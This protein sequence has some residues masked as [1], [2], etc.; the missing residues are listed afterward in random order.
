MRQEHRRIGSPVAVV[1]AV[2]R[3][4]GP[5]DGDVGA[6]DAPYPEDDLRS[7]RLMDRT[8]AKDP[9]VGGQERRVS[10]E[11]CL[12]VTRSRLFFALGRT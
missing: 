12:E 4:R 2:E 10:A 1:P 3:A 7:S 6:H 9:A 5:V 11:H 8:V